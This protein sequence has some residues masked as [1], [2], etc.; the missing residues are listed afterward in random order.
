MSPKSV[1]ASIKSVSF[2]APVHRA[3]T[4]TTLTHVQAGTKCICFVVKFY[5]VRDSPARATD[6]PLPRKDGCL[7][8]CSSCAPHQ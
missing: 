3:H 1:I 7:R 4:P 5:Q 2:E 8:N 6:P